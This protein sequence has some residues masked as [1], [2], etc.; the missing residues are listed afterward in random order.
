MLA[1]LLPRA[2][3]ELS[4][5]CHSEEEC[6]S[7]RDT[8]HI[9]SSSTMLSYASFGHVELHGPSEPGE[10]KEDRVKMGMS[11]PQRPYTRYSSVITSRWTLLR[12]SMEEDSLCDIVVSRI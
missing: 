5:D 10:M 7:V 1:G 12:P 8:D 11:L 3:L 4:R 6:D 9:S 2:L